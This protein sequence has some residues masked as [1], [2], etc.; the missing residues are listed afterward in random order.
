MR[1]SGAPLFAAIGSVAVLLAGSAALASDALVKAAQDNDVAGIVAEIEAGADV[2]YAGIGDITPLMTAAARGNLAAVEALLEHG[3]DLEAEN[4]IDYTALAIAAE[5]ASGSLEVIEALVRFG[6]DTEKRFGRWGL[7]PLGLAI[8]SG[9]SEVALKLMELGVDIAALDVTGDPP[10]NAAIFK[11]DEVVLRALLA[12][13]IDP[14]HLNNKK[15]DAVQFARHWSRLEFALP[16][17]LEYQPDL[18]K[19][20]EC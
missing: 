19:R 2:N 13:G 1:K 5:S 20:T 10:V 17:M 9:N 11:G 16:L 15:E 7:T 14:M 18:C 4:R 8:V 12:A 6:A 3:A